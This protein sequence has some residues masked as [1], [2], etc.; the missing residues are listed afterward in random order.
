[1]RPI[2]DSQLTVVYLSFNTGDYWAGLPLVTKEFV[3]A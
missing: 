3:R 1:M 2:D